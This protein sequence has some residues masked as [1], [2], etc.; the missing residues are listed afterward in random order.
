VTGGN[1]TKKVLGC[2]NI[3]QICLLQ[4]ISFGKFLD[5]SKQQT[6]LTAEYG[7]PRMR[8]MPR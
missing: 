4:L 5:F 7:G 6:A 3:N 2:F 1:F 8:L